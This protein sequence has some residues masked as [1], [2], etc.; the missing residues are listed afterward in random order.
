M[1][2][3]K[4]EDERNGLVYWRGCGVCVLVLGGGRRE[5]GVGGLRK[6]G[7]KMK[8]GEGEG[9]DGSKSGGR[10][11]EGRSGQEESGLRVGVRAEGGRRKRGDQSVGE[12][13]GEVE[14]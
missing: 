13:R 1:E 11:R 3:G 7:R 2:E 10:D 12:G 6:E 4:F 5:E 14:G 8:E 9:G